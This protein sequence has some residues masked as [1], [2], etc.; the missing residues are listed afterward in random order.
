MSPPRAPNQTLEAPTIP[1]SRFVLPPP[2][3]DLL[4]RLQAFLPQIKS[5][6]EA[7]FERMEEDGAEESVT[8]EAFSSDEDED[9]DEEAQGDESSSD[10]DSSEAGDSTT[11]TTP[12]DDR[13]TLDTRLVSPSGDASACSI[14]PANVGATEQPEDVSVPLAPLAHLLDI[15]TTS[16]AP[17]HSSRGGAAPRKQ[18]GRGIVEL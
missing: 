9:E 13:S 5:A 18:G 17:S 3:S 14:T 8:L 10:K 2:S 1:A 11:G 16:A 7:L 15:G 12:L 6:N 4:A